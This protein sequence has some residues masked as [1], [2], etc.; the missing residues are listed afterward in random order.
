[1]SQVLTYSETVY[2]FADSL[3]KD[4]SKLFNYDSHPSGQKIPY[5]KLAHMMVLAAVQ[6][7]V[8]K[9][10]VELMVKDVK[11]LFIFP[12]KDIFLKR[13]KTDNTDLTGIEKKLFDYIKDETKLFTAVYFLLDTDYSSPWGQI[14][15]LSKDSLVGKNILQKEAKAKHIFT[16][17]KYL[18]DAQILNKYESS[19]NI[20]QFSLERIKQ[21]IKIYRLIEKSIASGMAARVERS[22]SDD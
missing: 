20:V 16:T 2:L 8:E 9:Q 13:L 14:V 22:S 17:K 6:Y 10:Y 11:K 18:Y 12:G 7:L 3:I 5:V 4:R 1:M 19:L 15:I 21:D